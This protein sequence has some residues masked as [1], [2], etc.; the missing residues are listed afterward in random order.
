MLPCLFSQTLYYSVSLISQ[1]KLK[2]TEAGHTNSSVWSSVKSALRMLANLTWKVL[3]AHQALS[4]SPIEFGQASMCDDNSYRMASAPRSG[5]PDMGSL[6]GHI[7]TF[8]LRP[9]WL[10]VD[11]VYRW[12]S[13]TIC[14]VMTQNWPQCRLYSFLALPLIM[15]TLHKM[16]QSYHKVAVK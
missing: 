7:R 11:C 4:W 6:A 12:Q 9:K 10:T 15:P 2:T 8:L 16:Q 13:W 3:Q 14:K 1:K 5:V